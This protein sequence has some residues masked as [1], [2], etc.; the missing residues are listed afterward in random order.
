M[1]A[2][3]I[4]TSKYGATKQYAAWLAEML[5]L[6]SIPSNKILPDELKQLDVILLG[7][8]VYFGKFRLKTWLRRNTKMLQHKRLYL[9]II[10]ATALDEVEKRNNFIEH[11]VPLQLKPD[12][13]CFFLPGRVIHKQ[14]SFRDRFALRIAAGFEKDPIKRKVLHEDLNGVDKKALFPL[15][16]EVQRSGINK[17]Q[18]S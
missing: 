1:Q 11:N 4:Y 13:H 2:A 17:M 8:P 12:C 16:N 9:F 14:L 10:N 7:T 15:I 6:P 18:C 5:T 3:I